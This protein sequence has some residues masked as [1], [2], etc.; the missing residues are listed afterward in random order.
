MT[1]EN[2]IPPV[3]LSMSELYSAARAAESL[4]LKDVAARYR[5]E[6]ALEA[7][8]LDAVQMADAELAASALAWERADAEERAACRA[9]AEAAEA[10]LARLQSEILALVEARLRPLHDA[11]GTVTVEGGRASLKLWGTQSISVTVEVTE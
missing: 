10:L 5:H 9:Y 3:S 11:E 4:G 1:N 6:A 8:S 2:E 7:E